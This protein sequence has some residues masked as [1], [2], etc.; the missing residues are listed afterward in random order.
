MRPWSITFAQS[1]VRLLQAANKH[2]KSDC[3]HKSSLLQVYGWA[4]ALSL[5]DIV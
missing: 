2:G 3:L 5:V 4:E 1:N